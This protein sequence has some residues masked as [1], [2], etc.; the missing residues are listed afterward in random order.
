MPDWKFHVG[1]AKEVFDNLGYNQGFNIFGLGSIMPDCPW[2]LVDKSISTGSRIRSHYIDVRDSQPISLASYDLYLCENAANIADNFLYQGILSH[3]I[4]D[5]NINILW[6]TIIRSVE[7][8]KFQLPEKFIKE[9]ASDTE[10]LKI[11]WKST[12]AYSSCKYS[13]ICS[14][15]LQLNNIPKDIIHKYHLTEEDVN[16]MKF[17][18]AGILD[19]PEESNY[20]ATIMTTSYDSVVEQTVMEC[21]SIINRLKQLKNLQLL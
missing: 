11:K 4:L 19:R 1:V 7:S 21:V 10:L 9:E 12:E 16:R 6:R 17:S 13:S 20:V 15:I 5:R 8:N 14:D 2:M 18:I 3:L